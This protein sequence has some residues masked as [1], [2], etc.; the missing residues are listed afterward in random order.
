MNRARVGFNSWM[1]KSVAEHPVFALRSER[2]RT[3]NTHYLLNS[4][5]TVQLTSVVLGRRRYGGGWR[6]LSGP[7]K[8]TCPGDMARC[9]NWWTSELMPHQTYLSTSY[10]DILILLSVSQSVS[11]SSVYSF[12]VSSILYVSLPFILLTFQAD[13]IRSYRINIHFCCCLTNWSNLFV[14]SNRHRSAACSVVVKTRW[15][16]CRSCRGRLTCVTSGWFTTS[17]SGHGSSFNRTDVFGTPASDG[18]CAKSMR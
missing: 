3:S 12:L 9:A 2:Q 18:T 10:F 7:Y 16:P 14:G 13:F 15:T 1:T 17:A 6:G 11:Q 4:L 5:R 8:L